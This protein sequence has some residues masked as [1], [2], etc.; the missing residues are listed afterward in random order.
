MITAAIKSRLGLRGTLKATTGLSLHCQPWLNVQALKD[1]VAFPKHASGFLKQGRNQLNNLT[2]SLH[3]LKSR[4][5]IYI[6][7]S[8][9][10]LFTYK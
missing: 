7:I 9:Y 3:S 8:L 4:L 2:K 6:Y 10:M 1:Q 5:Y